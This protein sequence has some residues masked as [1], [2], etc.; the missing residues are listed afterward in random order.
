MYNSLT[1]IAPLI[2]VPRPII[3]PI[4]RGRLGHPIRSRRRCSISPLVSPRRRRIHSLWGRSTPSTTPTRS[5]RWRS[6]RGRCIIWCRSR[7]RVCSRSRSIHSRGC[8]S[9]HVSTRRRS[10]VGIGAP[11]VVCGCVLP[12]IVV[13]GGMLLWLVGWC[14]GSPGVVAAVCRGFGAGCE[15]V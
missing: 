15:T 14:F 9:R 13:G 1:L 12:G 8:R 3:L 6:R 5:R 7:S 10:I 11:V 2:N 4:C